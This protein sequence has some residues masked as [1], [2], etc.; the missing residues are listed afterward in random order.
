MECDMGDHPKWVCLS[1]EAFKVGVLLTCWAQK[2]AQ[3]KRPTRVRLPLI[4][5]FSGKANAAKIVKELEDAGKPDYEHGLLDPV[6]GGW[7]VHD[8]PTA[9]LVMQ[10][11]NRER[12]KVDALR[13]AVLARDGYICGICG[14]T[15]DPSD[16][17]IDHIY[18]IHRGGKSVLLNL[19]VTHSRCNLTRRY[20]EVV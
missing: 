10:E 11:R 16:V 2:Q 20:D 13:D 18:P 8:L 1:L 14:G 7:E 6:D 3:L 17:H 4:E 12:A 9:C 15:V 5:K 19:R